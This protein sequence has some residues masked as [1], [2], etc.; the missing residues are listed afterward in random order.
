MKVLLDTNIIIHREASTVINPDIGQLFLWLDKLKHT[1]T[2]HPLTIEELERNKDSKTVESM[3]IKTQSYYQIKNV[4]KIHNTVSQI[5]SGIDDKPN[6]LNDT[7][8]LNEVFQDRV[9]L[10]ITEDR[11]MHHK[12]RLLGISDRVYRIEEFLEKT[13]SEN[14]DQVNYEV[15]AVQNTDFANVALNDAF[16]DS[17]RADYVGFDKWFNKKADEICYV[18]YTDAE[19]SAFLFIKVEDSNEN[20]SD[21]KPQLK[22]KRRLKIGTFKVTANGFKI[23]ERF[24]KII[25]DNAEKFRVDEIYVTIFDKRDEQFRLIEMLKSWGFKQFGIKST[26]NGEELVFTKDFSKAQEIAKTS[27]KLS[28]P[29]FSWEKKFYMVPVYPDYHTELFPDSILNTESPLNFKENLPHRN[30]ISKVY[31][32]RSRFK[33]LVPGDVIVFYRTGGLY[34]GVA[35]T[36]GIVESVHSEIADSTEFL[37]LCRKRS[38]FSNDELLK[39]WDYNK[40]SRPFVVNF[41]Y[42]HSLP[43]RPNLKWLIENKIIKDVNSAPRGF[44]EISEEKFLKIAKYSYRKK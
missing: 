24:L 20:Y 25:F 43:R 21:I 28:F 17:F 37:K 41:L 13:I 39:H 4:A 42:A 5:C 32:S 34:K 35:T 14:P 1:K 33:G 30:A 23:G 11:K 10:L 44:E 15:L 31:L 19:L 9:D 27:A 40:N 22:P 6:D 12:A 2:I 16:F 8:L 26:K 36:I 3:R 18:C 7:I 29:F 38:V